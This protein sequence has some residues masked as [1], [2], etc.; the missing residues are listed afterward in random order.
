MSLLVPFFLAGLAALSLPLLL[1]LVRRTP[2]GR[3]SFSSLMFLEPTP[4]QL[5]RQ[6]GRAHV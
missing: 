5:T 4:P 3:Q 6:I 1:H 2:R